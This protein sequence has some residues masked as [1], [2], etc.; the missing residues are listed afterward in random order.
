MSDVVIFN[1]TFDDDGD[2]D[3]QYSMPLFDA[4]ASAMTATSGG[5]DGTDTSTKQGH[6]IETGSVGTR[7]NLPEDNFDPDQFAEITVDSTVT[8]G[9]GV[10]VRMSSG[11]GYGARPVGDGT[12]EIVRFDSGSA[13]S[14]ASGGTEPTVGQVLRLEVSGTS[15]TCKVNGTTQVSTT[16]SNHSTGA[17]GVYT[18]NQ[19]S[20]SLFTEFSCGHLSGRARRLPLPAVPAI[21]RLSRKRPCGRFL[22]RR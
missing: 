13:T 8:G 1:Q 2:L 19:A 22:T 10:L 20:Q 3:S 7:G 9:P 15:L 21:R 6:I 16:D 18:L 4:G 17:P 5:V 12:L 14:L 11:D